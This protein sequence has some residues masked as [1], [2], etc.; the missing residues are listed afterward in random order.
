M[1]DTNLYALLGYYEGGLGITSHRCLRRGGKCCFRRIVCACLCICLSVCKISQ[2][3]MN[4]FWW[5]FL[6]HGPIA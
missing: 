1:F 6:D 5:N 4:G 3:V 2:K